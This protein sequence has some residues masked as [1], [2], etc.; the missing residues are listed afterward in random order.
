MIILAILGYHYL[1]R[2]VN[3]RQR[4][5]TVYGWVGRGRQTDRQRQ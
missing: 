1:K 4:S 5:L 3:Q 2:Y